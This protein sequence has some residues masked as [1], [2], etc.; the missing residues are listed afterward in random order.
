MLK[1]KG[2]CGTGVFIRVEV[3]GGG[4]GSGCT[5]EID[6][7]TILE[8]IARTHARTRAHIH[9]HTHTGACVHSV[10]PNMCN[11]EGRMWNKS[12]IHKIH[13]F[14]VQILQVFYNDIMI[15]HL[16]K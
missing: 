15:H 1:D 5:V 8:T 13:K 11:K 14:T 12:K 2:D 3:D 9:T 6:I 16:Y 7:E 10:D 4:K